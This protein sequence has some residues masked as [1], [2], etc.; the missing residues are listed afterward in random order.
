MFSLVDILKTFPSSVGIWQSHKT[1]GA[2]NHFIYNRLG[3]DAGEADAKEIIEMASKVSLADQQKLVQE[4]M[5]AQIKSFSMSMD[6]ILLPDS[7][8]IGEAHELPPQ[9]TAAPCRSGLGFAVGSNDQPTERPVDR[10]LRPLEPEIVLHIHF[11]FKQ[12]PPSLQTHTKPK[13]LRRELTKVKP[14]ST[15]EQAYVPRRSSPCPLPIKPTHLPPL[16]GLTPR[17]REKEDPSRKPSKE[18]VL[19]RP[20][21]YPHRPIPFPRPSIHPSFSD[22]NF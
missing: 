10:K 18:R 13:E 22:L 20:I 9:P 4:N 12:F 14:V 6:E 16:V 19:R 17:E 7:K 11:T 5:H 1:L 8:R 15:A 21:P 2:L 3:R